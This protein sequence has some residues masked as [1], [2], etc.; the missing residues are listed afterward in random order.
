MVTTLYSA[1]LL[2]Q[3]SQLTGGV[4]PITPKLADC[5][6]PIGD[7]TTPIVKFPTSYSGTYSIAPVSPSRIISYGN[8]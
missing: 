5:Q 7:L 3:V 1:S 2:G 8:Q 4:L 6:T